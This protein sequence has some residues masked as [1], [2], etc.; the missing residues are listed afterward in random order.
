MMVEFKKDEFV[1]HFQS[2]VAI[3]EWLDLVNDLID[4]MYNEDVAMRGEKSHIPVLNLLK[5]L[6]PEYLDALK[7]KVK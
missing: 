1:I 7:M 5:E 6:Q 3:E 2:K 4:L